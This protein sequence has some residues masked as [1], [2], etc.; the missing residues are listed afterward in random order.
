MAP[1]QFKIHSLETAR[2]ARGVAVVIDVLRAFT[3]AAVATVLGA[4]EIRCVGTIE[5]ALALKRELGNAFVM[6]EVD[7]YA[8][9]EFDLNN[10]P[11]RLR[12]SDIRGK[13]ILMRA[14]ML[15][16]KQPTALLTQPPPKHI[17]PTSP[18]MAASVVVAA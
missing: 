9:P 17:Y 6:G 16:H 8:I 4:K 7:G 15:T 13:I 12:D 10:S 3:T 18:E 11:L 14:I 5:T 1:I 2:E